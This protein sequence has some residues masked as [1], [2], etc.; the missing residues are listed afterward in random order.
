MKTSWVLLLAPLLY[1][2][3][4]GQLSLDII[5]GTNTFCDTGPDGMTN[6]LAGPAGITEGQPIPRYCIQNPVSGGKQRCYYL[7][8]PKCASG[9]T[10]LVVNMHGTS[11]CPVWSTY[12]DRWT[13]TAVRHCFAVAY[14]IGVTDPDVSD[15]PCYSVPGGRNVNDVFT[16]N[17]CCCSKDGGS[18]DPGETQDLVVIHNMV[19]DI[20]FQ[21]R[22][23]LLTNNTAQM[24]ETRVYM[25]GHSNGCLAALGMGA[26]FSDLVAAVC[27]HAAGSFVRVPPNYDPI[28]TWIAQGVKDATIWYQ[29]ARETT[30][31]YGWI[32]Q[33][34]NET[35]TDVANGTGVEYTQ[36]NCTNNA[37][38]T[39]LLLNESGHIPFLSLW[40]YSEGA[41]PTT[42]DTTEMAW[43]FCS[44]YSK[45]EVP[46]SLV[47]SESAAGLTSTWSV[48]GI[49]V[50]FLLL[51][52]T[53]W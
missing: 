45:D 25:A 19:Q 50:S 16:T 22:V 46:P 3:V 53:L 24:D 14:P 30:Q 26:V 40:E 32:H 10:P 5:E 49:V 6:A 9:S 2:V 41:S 48:G 42:I 39:L 33:C 52:S 34:L 43:Q 7:F 51:V 37:S 13:E 21:K 17:D 23:D 27:C 20:V 18:L 44:S 28:P 38:V 29:F 11:S 15:Y 1:N 36:Y 35:E 47:R 8:V 31:T 4:E 12:F